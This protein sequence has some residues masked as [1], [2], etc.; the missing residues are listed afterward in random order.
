M[1]QQNN[2][3]ELTAASSNICGSVQFQYS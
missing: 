1:H 3:Q 2:C